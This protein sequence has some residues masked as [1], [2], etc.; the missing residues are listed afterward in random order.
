[1]QRYWKAPGGFSVNLPLPS[2]GRKAAME[3][4]H[5]LKE[6]GFI[7]RK[8]AVL[9]VEFNLYNPA[10]D[11]VVR[12]EIS[13]EILVGGF[14]KT[15]TDMIP[16]RASPYANWYDEEAMCDTA[17]YYTTG[18]TALCEPIIRV[19]VFTPYIHHIYII[20]TPNTPLNTPY[21]PYIRPVYTP[22]L[23]QV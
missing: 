10:L 8:T 23:F 18:I 5:S 20:Y 21:T 13:L 16:F 7:D 12:C 4:L 2:K 3:L 14:Y 15:H 6:G 1:M 22:L 17:S 9:L 11:I 19:H